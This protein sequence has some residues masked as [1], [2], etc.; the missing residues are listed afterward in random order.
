MFNFYKVREKGAGRGGRGARR[1]CGNGGGD[2]GGGGDFL[3]ANVGGGRS[4]RFWMRY[5]WLGRLRRRVSR[6]C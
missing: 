5:F 6:L 3:K 4:T 1:G 2:G